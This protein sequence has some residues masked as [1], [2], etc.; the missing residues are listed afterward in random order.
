MDDLFVV[1]G[2]VMVSTVSVCGQA[3][4]RRTRMVRTEGVWL[5]ASLA[6]VFSRSRW[7]VVVDDFVNRS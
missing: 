6:A 4:V 7:V 3:R 5:L 2:P 1:N